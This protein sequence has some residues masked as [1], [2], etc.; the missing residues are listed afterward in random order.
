[1]GVDETAGQKFI[2]VKS[3]EQSIREARK[4]GRGEVRRRKGCATIQE[5]GRLPPASPFS[6]IK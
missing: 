2:K 4:E 3:I 5:N 6:T 1:M